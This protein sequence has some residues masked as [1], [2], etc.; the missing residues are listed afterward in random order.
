[1]RDYISVNRVANLHPKV[2]EDVK[3][4]V[5]EAE[6]GFPENMAIRIVQGLRT[7]DE[8]NALYAQ[9]RTKPGPIVTKA[10]GGRS[11]HN[12][13]LAVDFA[14][15]K[16]K[17]NNGTFETLSW[18]TKED[19]DKD[20]VRDWME[21]VKV[22]KKYGWVWGGDFTSIKDDP[23]FEKSFNFKTAHLLELY[24]KKQRIPGTP[25]VNF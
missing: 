16:D 22:F 2:R 4:C 5:E 24:N 3:K 21:V 25:Y 11:Y 14:L 13:G 18:D 15:L 9:G 8:Q 12:Y 17:D 10:V 23:H 7:I 6:A 1:M 20:G 19:F